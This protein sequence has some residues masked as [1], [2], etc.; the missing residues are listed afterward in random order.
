MIKTDKL[1][2]TYKSFKEDSSILFRQII[3]LTVENSSLEFDYPKESYNYFSP[4]CL[5]I[6]DCKILLP[7][8]DYIMRKNW[9]RNSITLGYIND[10]SFTVVEIEDNEK[11]KIKANKEA[12]KAEIFL[13]LLNSDPENNTPFGF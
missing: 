11:L 6:K 13:K 1:S 12:L 7:D 8:Y 5:D 9:D 4:V 10:F 2:F 3:D